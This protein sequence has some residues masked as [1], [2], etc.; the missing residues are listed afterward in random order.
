MRKGINHFFLFFEDKLFPNLGAAIF[1]V[2]LFWMMIEAIS[3]QVFSKSY[4][5]SVEVITYSILWAAL[6]T[7]AQ[8]GKQNYHIAIDIVVARLP[9]SLKK[10]FSLFAI[11]MGLA[12][13][14]I[15]LYSSMS[16]VMHLYETGIRSHSP[17][18]LPM[19]MVTLAVPIGSVLLTLFYTRSFYETLR[20]GGGLEEVGIENSSHFHKIMGGNKNEK[21]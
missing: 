11:L 3:R 14:L 15:L 5:I 10:P 18:R 7:L 6:L 9:E 2:S 19:W 17:M 1:L 8:A 21:N 20:G 12:F 4:A 13:S 16:V